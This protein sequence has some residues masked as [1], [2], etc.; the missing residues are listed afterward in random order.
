MSTVYR[1]AM[2]SQ[3][4]KLP[5]TVEVSPQ[6][7]PHMDCYM[8]FRY[9]FQNGRNKWSRAITYIIIIISETIQNLNCVIFLALY[10]F[11]CVVRRY[12]MMYEHFNL[13][14][15]FYEEFNNM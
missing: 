4:K 7:G 5:R 13:R 9:P 11:G 12:C 15:L 2:L 8:V 10:M 3:K 6:N 14:A 1:N